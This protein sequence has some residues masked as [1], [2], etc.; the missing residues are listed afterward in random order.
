MP[1]F[2][3]TKEE[4]WLP[5][6]GYEGVYSVSSHGRIR[7]DKGG[8]RCRSGRIL[9]SANQNGYRFVGLYRDGI[10]ISFY[11]HRLVLEAFV[12][13]CPPKHECRHFP[14]SDRTNNRLENLSW[15]TRIENTADKYIHGTALAAHSETHPSAKLTNAEVRQ[16][17]EELASGGSDAVLA[18]RYGIDPSCINNIKHRKTWKHV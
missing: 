8:A 12:G 10:G 15:G 6:V 5:V 11:V 13:P 9:K 3:S 2:D 16:I 1:E 14:D 7:R 4:R 17:R 18:R